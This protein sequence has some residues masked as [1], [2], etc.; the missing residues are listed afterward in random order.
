VVTSLVA[1]DVI[2]PTVGF[3]VGCA[4]LLL[5]LDVFGWRM[6][7]VTLNRERLITGTR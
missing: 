2:H 6:L 3:A 4:G 5:L 1:F 7:S